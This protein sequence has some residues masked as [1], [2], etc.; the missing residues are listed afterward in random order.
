[1][2]R[3][4][5]ARVII[6]CYSAV[7]LGR[8]THFQASWSSDIFVHL[9]GLQ[10]QFGAVLRDAHGHQQ[11]AINNAGQTVRLQRHPEGQG[12]RHKHQLAAHWQKKVL[13]KELRIKKCVFLCLCAAR[14]SRKCRQLILQRHCVRQKSR[15]PSHAQ[16]RH[17]DHL[18][19]QGV[20]VIRY[21]PAAL[22]S[23]CHARYRQTASRITCKDRRCVGGS[24]SIRNVN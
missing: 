2:L 12:Q 13:F 11:C 18:C 9:P 20:R 17:P 4:F 15:Q 24:A 16:L 23:F 10:R 3:G 1:M 7:P 22:A 19:L 8:S 6:L 14:W 5:K 21:W